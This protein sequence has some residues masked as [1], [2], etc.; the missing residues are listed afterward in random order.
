M[1][2]LALL[3]S[4]S[5]QALSLLTRDLCSENKGKGKAPKDLVMCWTLWHFMDMV[6]L[7]SGW[8]H[9]HVDTAMPQRSIMYKYA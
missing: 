3:A 2:I 8:E 5:N 7:I 6:F 4:A 1:L 9:P